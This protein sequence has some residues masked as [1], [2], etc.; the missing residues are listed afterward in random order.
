MANPLIPFPGGRAGRYSVDNTG[1]GGNPPGMEARIARLEVFAESSDRR[2]SL[3]E[4]DIRQ[5]AAKMDKHFIIFITT[6]AAL[7]LVVSGAMWKGYVRLD[8]KIETKTAKIEA[9]VDKVEERLGKLEAR[10]EKM[11]AKLDAVLE[12]LPKGK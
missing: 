9:R 1:N 10:L 4:Q 8:D 7:F 12:R 11:D 6:V 5:M 3:I 2:L